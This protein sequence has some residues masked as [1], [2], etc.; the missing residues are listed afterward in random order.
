VSLMRLVSFDFCSLVRV[1]WFFY[2]NRE[3]QTAGYA[4]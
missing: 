1:F 3:P 4:Y 2:T